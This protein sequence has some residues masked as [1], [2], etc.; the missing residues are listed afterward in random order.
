MGRA[1]AGLQL[2]HNPDAVEE[3]GVSLHRCLFPIGRDF[4]PFCNPISLHNYHYFLDVALF[5]V[6]MERLLP[7]T[8]GIVKCNNPLKLNPFGLV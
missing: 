8:P 6:F 1:V 2:H 5:T 4:G 3:A 7:R